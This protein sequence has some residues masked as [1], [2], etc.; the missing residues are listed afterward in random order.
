M[1]KAI[2]VVSFGTT[3]K[4]TRKK[5]IETCE[6]KIKEN[7]KEY[8]VFG[9]Y[10][11]QRIIRKVKAK[12]NIEIENPTQVLDKLFEKGYKKVI[13]QSLHIVCGEEF[14]KL[15]DI[16]KSYEGK[17]EKI[18][19]GRPLIS[20][21]NDLKEVCYAIKDDI[22]K[23]DEAVLFIGHGTSNESNHIYKDLEN[24]LL[25]LNNNVHIK[26]INEINSIDSLIS[27]LK[28]KNIKTINL[29]ILMLVAGHHATNDM[30]RKENSWKKI[31]ERNGFNVNVNLKG[32]GENILIQDKFVRH[33]LECS[34]NLG[35]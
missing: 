32:L 5:T 23:N 7:L 12:E 10:T 31:L 33:A 30:I 22:P 4:E 18:I 17:F 21:D 6:Q 25:K 14:N 2:L 15:K 8:D 3:Y 35:D 29:M 24:V 9:A 34:K 16:V 19:L 11:S 1:K 26:T 27:R 20:N 28:E 13:V